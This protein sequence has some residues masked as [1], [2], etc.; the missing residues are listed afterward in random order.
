MVC[1]VIAPDDRMP[2]GLAWTSHS[3]CQWE[4]RK[5]DAVRV[6]MIL[7]QCFVRADAGVMI[8]ITGLS[9][10]N[11]WMQQQE[12]VQLFNR[13]LCHLLVHAMQ[14]IACL[15]RND[16]TLSEFIQSCSCFSWGEAQ[17]LKIVVRWKLNNAKMT[18]DISFAPAIHFRDE[19]MTRVLSIKHLCCDFIEVPVVDLFDREDG[20]QLVPRVS[21]GDITV[22]TDRLLFIDG[23]SDRYRKQDTVG[24]PHVIQH[25]LIISFSHE[26]M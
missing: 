13:C 19:R 6:V 21:K 26:A 15:E 23:Q 2:H 5:Q 10:S 1:T 22:K 7:R 16:I 8:N 11:R 14:R 9:H 4:E 25:A 17:I 18:R 12:A 20:E 3:H 24:K